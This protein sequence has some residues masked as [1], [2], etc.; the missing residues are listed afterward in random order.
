MTVAAAGGRVG[1]GAG[2]AG[3]PLA[4]GLGGLLE[5]V[6]LGGQQF[7]QEN[8]VVSATRVEHKMPATLG[9]RKR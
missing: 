2:N 6:L 7:S 1:P 5:S 3:L 8:G 4:Q 9:P